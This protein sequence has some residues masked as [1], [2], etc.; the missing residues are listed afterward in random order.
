MRAAVN[1][2]AAE[3]PSSYLLFIS[4]DSEG[5]P[6]ALFTRRINVTRAI[7]DARPGIVDPITRPDSISTLLDL[8][9]STAVVTAAAPFGS[10]RVPS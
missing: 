7:G 2:K 4:I 10:A 1:G 9:L 8:I 5:A 3:P 6:F